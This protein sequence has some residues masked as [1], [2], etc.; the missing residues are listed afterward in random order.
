LDEVYVEFFI[1][2]CS[3][4][5]GK[6]EITVQITRKGTVLASPGLSIDYRMS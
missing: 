2:S 4:Y 3:M 5:Y 1:G 6:Q